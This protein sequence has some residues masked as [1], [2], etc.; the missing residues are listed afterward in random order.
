MSGR[1][2]A[3][4]EADI[5]L[6]AYHL[7][8]DAHPELGNNALLAHELGVEVDG[9]FLELGLGGSVPTTRSTSSSPGCASGSA[10]SRS[11]SPKARRIRRVAIISGGGRATCRT[12]P[13]RATTS[14]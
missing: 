11:S 6:A 3:L 1:L 13:P 2:Q 12:Q 4:F 14:F 9:P 5:N 7:A 10:A 8:L